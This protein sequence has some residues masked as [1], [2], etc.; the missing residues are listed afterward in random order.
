[1][2]RTHRRYLYEK[3]KMRMMITTTPT[4]MRET[5]ATMTGY[6]FSEVNLRIRKGS[7]G[8][9]EERR[10]TRRKICGVDYHGSRT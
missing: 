8:L 9:P 5:E 4:G 7:R 2:N 6:Q 3:V 1:M 10:R